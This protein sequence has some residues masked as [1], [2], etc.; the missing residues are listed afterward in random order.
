MASGLWSMN[1]WYHLA[2][3]GASPAKTTSGT[4]P[5]T[6]VASAVMICVKPGPQ[7]VDATP[8]LPVALQ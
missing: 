8:T 4:L 2:P 3:I 6:A 1:W 7:V 5:R